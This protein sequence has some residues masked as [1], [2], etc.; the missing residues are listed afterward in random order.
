MSITVSLIQN[1]EINQNLM[2][3]LDHKF[4]TTKE[5]ENVNIADKVFHCIW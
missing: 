4:F 1:P 3:Q 5:L 2:V